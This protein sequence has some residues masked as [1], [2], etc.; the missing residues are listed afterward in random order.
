MADESQPN[1][2]LDSETVQRMVGDAT[3]LAGSAE[4]RQATIDWAARNLPE[5]EQA[6]FNR[7]LKNPA[8]TRRAFAEL[9]GKRQQHEQSQDGF[10]A[11][12]SRNAGG[13]G[14]RAE[15]EQGRRELS[16]QE[17]LQKLRR[18]NPSVLGGIHPQPGRGR[19]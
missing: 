16:R 3:E 19:V 6:R 8:T 4:E 13:Y 10:L 7:E 17:H 18:T 15:A 2:G 11:Q 5:D 1:N 12:G 9:Q 14:S